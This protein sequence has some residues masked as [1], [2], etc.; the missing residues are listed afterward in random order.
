MC[1]VL[2]GH[3]V[4]S[5]A[6]KWE[7]ARSDQSGLI[8]R[9]FSRTRVNCAKGPSSSLFACSRHVHCKHGRCCTETWAQR[10][11]VATVSQAF[12]ALTD[13]SRPNT[14]T[15][16]RQASPRSAQTGPPKCPYP[17]RG[18][19]HAKIQTMLRQGA[20]FMQSQAKGAKFA[21]RFNGKDDRGNQGR[22]IS[23][24]VGGEKGEGE[25]FTRPPSHTANPCTLSMGAERG[26]E[27]A[28]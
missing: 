12:P 10:V 11:H 1:R 18:L 20:T 4:Y 16:L 24:S 3:L 5:L 25:R 22:A 17:G 13:A 28:V 2:L 23:G 19:A 14:Q 7:A 15:L 6:R 9:P 21:R 27:K 8:P 26:E